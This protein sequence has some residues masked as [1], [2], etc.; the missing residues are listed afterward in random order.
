MRTA[1]LAGP[2]AALVL[3][4]AAPAQAATVELTDDGDVIFNAA[5]G[6]AATQVEADFSDPDGLGNRDVELFSFGDVVTAITTPAG[7]ESL[8]SGAG[9]SNVA[10]L[11]I[12]GQRTIFNM[13][14]GDDVVRRGTPAADTLLGG[15]G[16][17]SLLGGAGADVVNGGP[18]DDAIEDPDYVNC[19]N[20][21]GPL[22]G[23]AGADTLIGGT[24]T[25]TWDGI[26]RDDLVNL[27][28]NGAADDG[29]AGEGDNVGG[30]IEV[31]KGS[32]GGIN[33]TGNALRNIVSGSDG[34]NTIRGGAGDDRLYGGVEND[35]VDGGP[36][37]DQVYGFGGG[38]TV[39][40][41]PGQDDIQGE[42]GSTISD[43]AGGPDTIQA[44]DGERD[45][46][47]C[48]S[49]G[50]QAFTDQLDV[51]YAGG[52]DVC[53]QVFRASV[54]GAVTRAAA[55]GL[56]S[57]TAKVNGGKAAVKIKCRRATT[58]N[59][60]VTLKR[61]KKTLGAA[62]FSVKAGKTKTVKVKLKKAGKAL[63]GRSRKAKVTAS[64]KLTG[65]KAAGF[66]LTLK[67]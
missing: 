21:A 51:V 61:K 56:G 50:D 46:V 16:N 30:D 58:C 10:C 22:A 65:A 57:K 52:R 35:T 62:R 54:G 23:Q 38:D 1:F 31:F 13:G 29:A 67:R 15:D 34:P 12:E 17:D 26:C 53:E 39:I 8:C 9:T 4:F 36:G 41:G 66:P 37:T 45:T 42:G 33:F 11:H 48:G 27:S 63:L 28:L 25:D 47:A 5:G 49:F 44:R 20:F 24:G 40:G 3:V 18:G 7:L 6:T 60:K 32:R 59:G 19:T 64:I 14:A 2:L 55:V 43:G